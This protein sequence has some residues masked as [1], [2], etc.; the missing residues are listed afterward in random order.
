MCVFEVFGGLE[1]GLL[2]VVVFMEEVGC[3]LVFGLVVEIL[4]VMCLL[5]LFGVELQVVLFD[6]VMSGKF[7]VM[8]VFYDIVDEFM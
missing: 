6:D 2:D 8:I 1:L 3:I 5:V 4:V 7:V